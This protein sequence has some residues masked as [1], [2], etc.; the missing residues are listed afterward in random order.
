MAYVDDQLNLHRVLVLYLASGRGQSYI[1]VFGAELLVLLP[2]VVVLISVIA[3]DLKDSF[4][5][6]PVVVSFHRG[7]AHE[8]NSSVTLLV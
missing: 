8:R 5:Y 4:G 7:Y 2:Q 3:W 6:V 1:V